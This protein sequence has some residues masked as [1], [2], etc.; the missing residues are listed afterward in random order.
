MSTLWAV[1][2]LHT[3]RLRFLRGLEHQ[4][5][6]YLVCRTAFAKGVERAQMGRRGACCWGAKL[7]LPA[8]GACSW[9]LRGQAAPVRAFSGR[10]RDDWVPLSCTQS[11]C[12][13]LGGQQQPLLQSE[14]ALAARDRMSADRHCHDII[15][16]LQKWL[17]ECEGLILRR[18]LA[19]PTGMHHGAAVSCS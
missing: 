8:P 1:L 7:P 5:V 4:W 15:Q 13:C 17:D 18:V 11:P 6:L 3:S 10:L 14:E 19:L 9:A 12:D 2:V 16:T